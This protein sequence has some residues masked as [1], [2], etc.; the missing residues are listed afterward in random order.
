MR[1]FRPSLSTAAFKFSLLFALGA[2]LATATRAGAT[3]IGTESR[4]EGEVVNTFGGGATETYG[5]TIIA[6]TESVLLDFTF[7]VY[8]LDGLPADVEGQVYAWD[9]NLEAGNDPQGATGPALFSTPLTIEPGSDFEAVTVDTGG[10][11]LIAGDAYILL[12]TDPTD[13]G[14][15]FEFEV[16]GAH[17]RRAGRG[18]FNYFNN[19]DPTQINNGDWSANDDVNDYGD[20]AFT[21]DFA[22]SVTPI[23]EPSSLMLLATGLLGA[24]GA[25][26][27]KAKA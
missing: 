7:Y 5:E 25:I 10:L 9:G 6:P 24:A 15:D 14:G 19:S 17:P 18:G 22:N 27:R 12:L 2:S 8:S 13:T 4:W 11:Q 1:S 3:T 23:P 26:R 21:A 16:V 20:L